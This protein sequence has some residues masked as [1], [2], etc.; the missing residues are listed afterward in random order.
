MDTN[1]FVSAALKEDSWPGIVVSWLGRHGG[2]LK[3][4][5]TEFEVME[6]LQRPRLAK[7]ISPKFLMNLQ[8]IFAV[9]EE[10]NITRCVAICR[11]EKDDK[12]LELALN[13]QADIIVSGDADLLVLGR[14]ETIPIIN[15]AAF[16][17]TLI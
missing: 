11:D 12:F 3:S 8:L 17:R 15:P 14:F 4:S 1:V 16:A 7:R 10:V 5:S 9:S 13:G 6:I 2:L